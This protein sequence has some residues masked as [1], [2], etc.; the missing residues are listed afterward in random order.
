MLVYL[1]SFNPMLRA[2]GNKLNER[3][4]IHSIKLQAMQSAQEIHKKLKELQNY[5]FVSY[6]SQIDKSTH[7]VE[8]LIMDFLKHEKTV[9]FAR[10]VFIVKEEPQGLSAVSASGVLVVNRLT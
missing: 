2:E 1:N 10:Q 5:R 6:R 9:Q 7:V 8:L 3:S 4:E